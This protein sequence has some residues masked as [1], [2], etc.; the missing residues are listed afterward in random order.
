VRSRLAWRLVLTVGGVVTTVLVLALIAVSLVTQRTANT[1]SD[2]ALERT[3]RLIGVLLQERE[4]GLARAVQVFAQNPNFRSL[5]LGGRP[6][7]VLD[8]AIEAAQRTGATWVQVTDSVGTRLAKSDEPAAAASALAGSA[9]IAGA[10][11]GE[12]TGGVGTSGDTALFQAIAVP[13]IGATTV[14]GA[15]M[16]TQAID[17]ALAAEVRATTESE[18]AF[19]VVGPQGDAHVVASTFGS[20]EALTAALSGPVGERLVAGEVEA[21]P[22]ELS[23]GGLDYVGR[24]AP[25]RSAAGEVLG[26]V[27]AF[28]SHDLEMAPFA[29]LRWAILAAGGAGLG[30]A[31]VLAT[32]TG[33][34]LAEPILAL[35]RAT[36]RVAEGNYD[37]AVQVE[38]RDEIGTLAE[39]IRQMITDLRE[40][41]ALV[42]VLEGSATARAARLE[43]VPRAGA[44][45]PG[46]SVAEDFDVAPGAM[47]AGRY[48][49]RDALGAGGG[50]VVYRAFDRELGEMIALKTLHPDALSD[51][52]EALERFKSELRLARRLTH[53]NIVRTYDLGVA[54]GRYWITMELVSGTSLRALLD[55]EGVLPLAAALAIG[56]QLF[57]ALDVAHDAGILHRDIKPQNLMVQPDGTLKVMDFGIARAITRASGLTQ[58]GVVMGTPE[59]MAPEQLLGEAI[60]ARS[61]LFSAGVVLFECVTGR[62]PIEAESPAVLIAR[63][64]R[65]PMPTAASIAPGVPRDLSDLLARLL[66]RD[67][68][69]RPERGSRVFEALQV[70]EP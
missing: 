24:A 59:Y 45:S 12:S 34:S 4:A 21:V 55:R 70:M 64:L 7:D 47:L 43:R 22:L 25:L 10:L 49:I 50:G 44:V 54:G 37:V 30:V 51:D 28:R 5:L 35:T 46:W 52:P 32:L 36:R 33:R 20:D 61:D 15:L 48:E 27:A 40:K 53:R 17:S 14:A 68:Q 62:R 69:Q 19:F 8:Q 60:D 26:G 23:R 66:A 58:A 2:T 57:R 11:A 18:V 3:T 13:V 38:A 42:Q 16:A 39:S 1:T 31:F 29:G 41:A 67:P 6:Q 9:L 56:K 63:L 65:D